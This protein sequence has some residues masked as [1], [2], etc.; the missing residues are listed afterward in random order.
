MT[1]AYMV[2]G[3]VLATIGVIKGTVL[4]TGAFNDLRVELAELRAE[5]RSMQVSINRLE[6]RHAS[7]ASA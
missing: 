7:A 5:V 2:S 1:V 6:N 3:L 4:I